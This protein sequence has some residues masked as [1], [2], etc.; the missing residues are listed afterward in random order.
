MI[1][2]NSG[3]SLSDIRAVTGN[4]N[5]G[6]GFGMNNGA[7]W[8]IILFLFAFMGWGGRGWGG[9]GMMGGSYGMNNGNNSYYNGMS[10]YNDYNGMSNRGYIV[11]PYNSYRR[12]R[13][14]AMGNY[15]SRDDGKQRT[16]EELEWMMNQPNLNDSQRATLQQA[17]QELQMG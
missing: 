10:S 6:G 13:S 2:E 1:N 15:M 17:M 12:G 9:G 5:D 4:N 14:M 16:M 11:Q 7:W 8:I 3:Y